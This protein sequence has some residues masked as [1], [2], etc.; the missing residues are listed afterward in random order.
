MRVY[1]DTLGCPKNMIDS[2]IAA[3]ILTDAGHFITDTPDDAEAIIVNTCGFID[4]AKEESINR[5]F[6]L[7]KYN[8]VL[9]VSGCLSERYKDKL[10]ALMP[11]VDIFLGVNDYSRLPKLLKGHSKKNQTVCFSSISKKFDEQEF[12]KQLGPSH[13]SYLRIAEGCDNRCSYCAIPAIRGSYRSRRKETVFEEAKMLA[14]RGTAELILVAQDLTAYGIDI[15][16]RYCL[17]ELLKMLC[18]IDGICWIRLMYCCEDR[19]TDELI[20]VM[21][22]QNKICKYID[23]PVQHV[24]DNILKAMN[25]RSTGASISKTIKALREAMPNI[26]LRTTLMTGFPGET[27]KDFNMLYDYV[28]EMKFERLGV[29]HFSLEEGTRAA[30]MKDQIREDV[31]IE[32]KERIMVLQR[33]I[34]LFLNRGKI[35]KSLE[36]ITEGKKEDGRYFGRSR[37]DAP[38]I[39]NSVIFTSRRK[40]KTGDIIDVDIVDALDYDLLGQ[41]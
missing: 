14:A 24:S 6:E 17:P 12:R 30:S 13:Y 34:S 38:E 32:R 41:A 40:L 22:E 31:R 8:A 39:D 20:E 16:G 11:E 27:Q 10:P 33:E 18:S 19:I 23:M 28:G 9:A 15:Y 5:I 36:V 35:G 26:H 25:R 3:G 4:D 1:I 2:E 29:F 7:T 21:S 37:F